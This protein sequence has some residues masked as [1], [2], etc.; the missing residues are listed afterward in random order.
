MHERST[1]MS[2]HF[3]Y[4]LTQGALVCALLCATT[5]LDATTY[6]VKNT[7]DA[8]PVGPKDSLR[9]AI[10]A[11]NLG[12]GGDTIV[13]DIPKGG[14]GYDPAT[15]T[16]TI[17]PVRD[18][19]SI[20]KQVTI[21]GYSPQMGSSPN[22]LAVGG[23]NAVLTIVLSGNNYL[24]GNGILTG[25]GLHFL[26]GSDGSIVRGL[27]VN[28]W[29][30][31]GILI[32]G[33][34]K[35]HV[36]LSNIS[37]RGCFIGTDASGMH[38]QANRAG[39][40]ISGNH[41]TCVNTTIGTPALADRNVI[42]G[43]FSPLL[44]DSFGLGGACIYSLLNEGTT[45]TNNSIGT[46]KTGTSALGN[47]SYGIQLRGDQNGTISNN[48][49]SGHSIF[50]IRLRATRNCVVQGNSIGTDITGT[51]ALANA[52]AGVELDDN[53]QGIGNCIIHNLISGN[54][55]GIHI[56]QTISPGSILN[57]VQGNFIGTDISGTKALPN[58]RFGIIVTDSQNTIGGLE[59]SQAN[60]ISG[61]LGGGILIYGTINTTANIA[62]NNLIGT[63]L[64]G[65]QPL[66]NKGDG[67]QIGLNGAFGGTSG[68]TIGSSPLL[69]TTPS[70]V[71]DKAG[72]H[73]SSEE[74]KKQ[75]LDDL[76]SEPSERQHSASELNLEMV[77]SHASEAVITM[78]QITK[79]M[80]QFLSQPAQSIGFNFTAATV[81]DVLD[82]NVVPPRPGGW[83]GPQ[84]YIVM[85]YQNIRSFD[86][87][88]GLP[89]G[90]LD[91][92]AS[93]FFGTLS[94][95]DVQIH[96][97]RF[98]DR[99]VFNCI[100]PAGL[101]VVWSDSGVITPETVYTRA[102]FAN[103][104]LV[105]QPAPPVAKSGPLLATDVNAVYVTLDFFQSSNGT[106]LGSSTLVIA[107]S[108]IIT[109]NTS[110]AFTVFPGVISGPNGATFGGFNRPANNF[111]PDAEF[112]YLIEAQNFTY[113]CPFTEMQC[114]YTQ[115]FL[116]RIVNPG[117]AHPTFGQEL[118]LDVPPYS[119]PAPAPHKGNLYTLLS[120]SGI[121]PMNL[122]M[123]DA[124]ALTAPHV[125]NKQLYAC[126]HIQ[127]NTAGVGTPEGTR[128][129]VRWYQFDLTGDPTGNGCGVETET[130]CPA[131]VQWG[132]IFD[133][134]E[135]NPKF[136]FVPA[137]MTNKNGD[138]VIEGTVSGTNDY[139]NVF[140]AGRKATDQL[141]TLRD[142]VLVTNN[143]NP[144]NFGPQSNS[145][146]Q[147]WGDFSSLA[148]DPSNDLII[149]GAGEW[150]AIKNGWGI[151]SMQ[152]LPTK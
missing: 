20:I 146:G 151:Q 114:T 142:P 71:L 46:D 98:L 113:P 129:G 119:D 15:N 24:T 31:N 143:T 80:K 44:A 35:A 25:N 67:I 109:G 84:Q 41:G 58:Q 76:P 152:L 139:T 126:H 2:Q 50:G 73:I 38:E 122:S 14:P 70:C 78:P 68:N 45:I 79:T 131:L 53:D 62:G 49:I 107:N 133:S 148:P 132:T 93:N 101:I 94:A 6:I 123:A 36:T 7:L 60:V 144:Y 74:F 9:A 19:D 61:N 8:F 102:I 18:L 28:Q 97:S 137:I 27:V 130:T 135:D 116:N 99:W 106:Y 37:I 30:G 128:V 87:T 110:P 89:D 86:K 77:Q 4:L 12:S 127:V 54:G 1:M 96:Y 39:I 115:L 22:T 100:N 138:L 140:Y 121:N 66:P 149:W 52:N 117:S 33:G 3:K 95:N 81:S 11:V 17:T 5:D 48:L 34:P 103:N 64:T 145:A 23:S 141:G 118:A 91:I 65:T 59:A 136:Y 83:V 29:L 105:S 88:T 10:Q 108:S 124:A 55:T 21:D 120:S 82:P 92:E 147:R 85:S 134:A 69:S 57:T 47:S 16:W 125:R 40:G 32:D 111:D 63:D 13:F 43:S 56:G 42:A 75:T 150:A 104:E 90:V 26:P 51:K 72:Q 112:G